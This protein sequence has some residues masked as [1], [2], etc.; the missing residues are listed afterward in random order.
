MVGGSAS[1]SGVSVKQA[2]DPA[3]GETAPTQPR[4]VGQH[5]STSSASVPYAYAAVLS[6]VS[7]VLIAAVSRRLSSAQTLEWLS[8]AAV[9]IVISLTA[10]DPLKVLA[11]ARLQ[12]LA[13]TNRHA[14][15]CVDCLTALCTGSTHPPRLRQTVQL[16]MKMRTGLD[17]LHAETLRAHVQAARER[18]EADQA[19]AHE[20]EMAEAGQ[21]AG[22]D[23][24]AE[25]TIGEIRSQLA[26]MQQREKEEL[27]A[28]LHY[29]EA[30]IS[31]LLAGRRD[32]FDC[33]RPIA[34]I[35]QALDADAAHTIMRDYNE[36]ASRIATA[37]TR[38]HEES[39]QVRFP[40]ITFLYQTDCRC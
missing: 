6:L 24:A 21:A 5:R 7:I 26:S 27:Q 36:E 25:A 18:K 9:S 28:H 20:K 38:D 34:G 11:L 33:V 4:A 32:P 13:A 19:A 16:V 1:G 17:L 2:A 40:I 23:E 14:A 15:R 8:Y 3:S 31:T 39:L 30:T 22:N 12:R 37:R 10:I 35:E 29:V